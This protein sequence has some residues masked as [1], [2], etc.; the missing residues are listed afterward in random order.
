VK[1]EV[2]CC[3]EARKLL[4]WIDS[5]LGPRDTTFLE[6]GIVPKLA[7]AIR[8]DLSPGAINEV[9]DFKLIRLPFTLID[10]KGRKYF[11]LKADGVDVE[12]LRK[13][14]CFSEHYDRI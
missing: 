13:L 14:K 5:V 11:A 3:C 1:Y 2:R 4:G 12:D 10:V 8:F 6:F 9:A 7:K